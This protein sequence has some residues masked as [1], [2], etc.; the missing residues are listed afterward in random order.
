MKE[1]VK[2]KET[3]GRLLKEIFDKNLT[4]IEPPQHP[5]WEHTEPNTEQHTLTYT[6]MPA[7]LPSSIILKD[8]EIFPFPQG[9]MWFA[10]AA[11]SEGIRGAFVCSR[12]CRASVSIT[13][14]IV[15]IERDFLSFTF[16]AETHGPQTRDSGPCDARLC[17]CGTQRQ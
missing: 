4:S 9:N 11:E 2:W 15:Y 8:P 16:K 1:R 7:L 13:A 17:L 6:E 3:F 14:S 12:N 10:S 5:P